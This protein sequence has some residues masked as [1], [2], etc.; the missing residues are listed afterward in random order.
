M[1]RLIDELLGLSRVTRTELSIRPV[2]LSAIARDI[3]ASLH[4]QQPE[5]AVA[6]EIEEGLTV[7][8]DKSLMQIAMQNLLENAWKFTG[9]TPNPTIRVGR[10]HGN[11]QPACFVAD[12]IGRAHV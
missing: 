8:A 10:T 1:G 7:D 5:R 6:W 4:Q 11:G 2:D 12:K 3:A 9:K